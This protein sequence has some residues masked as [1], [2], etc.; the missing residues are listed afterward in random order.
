[1]RPSSDPTRK[2]DVG[3]TLE[4]APIPV[5]RID[6]RSGVPQNFRQE[7]FLGRP[8]EASHVPDNRSSCAC[9]CCTLSPGT[10]CSTC[11]SRHT[12]HSSSAC[13]TGR[14]RGTCDEKG[15]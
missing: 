13:V 6:K 11:A 3:G 12:Y 15:D 5:R 7:G 10:S 4:H 8:I 14:S 2:I 1:M 9:A